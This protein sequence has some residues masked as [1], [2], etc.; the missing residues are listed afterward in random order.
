MDIKTVCLLEFYNNKFYKHLIYKHCLFFHSESCIHSC[1]MVC[2]WKINDKLLETILS[3][4]TVQ[5]IHARLVSERTRMILPTPPTTYAFSCHKRRWPL[6]PSD[7]DSNPRYTY[8]IS[9]STRSRSSEPTACSIWEALIASNTLNVRFKA[10]SCK[11]LYVM[12]LTAT[13]Y[14][15][16]PLIVRKYYKQCRKESLHTH[17]EPYF[18]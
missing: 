15:H 3:A 6:L 7:G 10:L 11:T 13:F 18:R 4:M 5:V 9:T 17:P 12:L 16:I 1:G 2:T 8:F 14:F